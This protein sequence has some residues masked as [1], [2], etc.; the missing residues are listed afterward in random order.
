MLM[1]HIMH[2]ILTRNM[3]LIPERARKDLIKLVLDARKKCVEYRENNQTECPMCAVFGMKGNVRVDK[4]IGEIRYCECRNCTATFPAIGAVVE[5]IKTKK[6]KHK[7][8]RR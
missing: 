6:N 7:G 5:K 3:A 2:L 1:Q 8:K 4:T